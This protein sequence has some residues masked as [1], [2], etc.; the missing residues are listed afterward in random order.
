MPKGI[1]K[2]G[3]NKGWFKREYSKNNY[4]GYKIFYDK[5]G[6]PSIWLNGKTKKVHILV[7]EEVYGIKPKRHDVHHKDFNKGNYN[8]NNLELL[9]YSDHRKVHAGW[10]RKNNEWIGKP[11]KDC[12][13][14]LSLN[15][16]YPRNGLTPSNHCIKCNKI[17]WKNKTIIDGKK[18]KRYILPNEKGEYQCSVCLKWKLKELFKLRINNIPTSYCKSCFN[19]YQNKRNRRK[20]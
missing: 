9:S 15:M 3:L 5:K 12:K 6:Y 14:I 2:N 7:W 4:K 11:C 10:V 16:F 19:I 18:P 17:Y 8:I 20:L 13:Q 1:P